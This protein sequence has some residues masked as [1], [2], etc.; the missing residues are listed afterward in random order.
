MN[1]KK[2][3]TRDE[4]FK[5]LDKVLNGYTCSDARIQIQYDIVT[6]NFQSRLMSEEDYADD[7]I[8]EDAIYD[9][10]MT[11]KNRRF[12]FGDYMNNT[13]RL[14]NNRTAG[15]GNYMYD[16]HNYLGSLFNNGREMYSYSK[17]ASGIDSF[18]FDDSGDF[19]SDNDGSIA[20]D[21]AL[22]F[23]GDCVCMSG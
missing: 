23:D 15:F 5:T 4:Y 21:F 8:L 14:Y 7:R 22:D 19:Y 13:V 9:E 6:L 17:D 10:Y 2:N 3:K 16:L 18:F 11:D 1:V 12:S 20:L